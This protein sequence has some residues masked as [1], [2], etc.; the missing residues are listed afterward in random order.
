MESVNI[1]EFW[2]TGPAKLEEARADSKQ[3][4]GKLLRRLS[5]RVVRTERNLRS[6]VRA[7]DILAKWDRK[8]GSDVENRK[9]AS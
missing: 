4:S 7:N 3:K 6:V 1:N 2:T 9:G 5:V 8:L